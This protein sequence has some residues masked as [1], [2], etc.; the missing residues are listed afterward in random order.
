MKNSNAF[1]VS[2]ALFVSFGLAVSSTSADQVTLRNGDV[3]NG[4]VLAVTTNSLTLRDESLGTLT[5]PRVKIANIKFGA[6]ATALPPGAL[7]LTYPNAI[8]AQANPGT[9]VASPSQSNSSF[10]RLQAMLREV[11]GHGN[12][13]REVEAEVLGSGASPA[14]VN[15][16]NELLDG[17]S[18]GQIDL[19]GLRSQAQSAVNELQEYRNELGPDAGDELGG[20]L[21]ILNAFLRDTAPTNGAAP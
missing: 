4:K 18:S 21:S 9:A 17:L 11:R 10:S 8:Q 19:N 12:L 20:Y 16:F 1:M 7:S 3:L 15:K 13:V 6:M 14:A 5:L 2:L